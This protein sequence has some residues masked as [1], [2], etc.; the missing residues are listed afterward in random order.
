MMDICNTC[1]FFEFG[2]CSKSVLCVNGSKYV[3]VK[4]KTYGIKKN[5]NKQS[6][7][8]SLFFIHR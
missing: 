6:Q 7:L 8:D 2:N 1:K 3:P 4:N 5:H